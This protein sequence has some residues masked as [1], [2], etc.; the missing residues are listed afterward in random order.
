[1]QTDISVWKPLNITVL[2]ITTTSSALPL[3]EVLTQ[4][5]LSSL[6]AV[7]NKTLPNKETHNNL[8]V[9][10]N[11]RFLN[12]MILDNVEVENTQHHEV[13]VSFELT[14]SEDQHLQVNAEMVSIIL[15]LWN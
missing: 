5:K 6:N 9:Y 7:N 15:L 3:V 12:G 10:G 8:T 1:M 2:I 13:N 14:T 4:C 11:A